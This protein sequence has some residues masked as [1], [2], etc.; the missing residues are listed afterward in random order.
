M[1]KNQ[2][3][4]KTKLFWKFLDMPTSLSIVMLTQ[5]L[6]ELNS[7]YFCRHSVGLWGQS[8]QAKIC[9]LWHQ[10]K[11]SNL[12]RAGEEIEAAKEDGS[13]AQDTHRRRCWRVCPKLDA[14]VWGGEI[15]IVEFLSTLSDSCQSRVNLSAFRDWTMANFWA[16]DC[17][18]KCAFGDARTSWL[19]G[20]RI[21]GGVVVAIRKLLPTIPDRGWGPPPTLVREEAAKK[22]L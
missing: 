12:V 14:G 5:I 11:D 6:W 17:A 8:P 18:K 22:H 13:V 1:K 21:R 16:Q 19:L 3:G 7:W 10:G 2:L 20:E 9:S 15:D 4:T